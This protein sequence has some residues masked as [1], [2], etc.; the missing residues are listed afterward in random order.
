MSDHL[1]DDELS[2]GDFVLA[3]G[4]LGAL[5]VIETVA[6]LLPEVLGNEDSAIDESLGRPARYRQYTRP[7][8]F[9]GWEVPGVLRSGDH[10]AV[11]AWRHLQ[12]L[13]RTATRRPDLLDQLRR[14]GRLSDDDVR[15]LA[16]YGYDV[17]SGTEPV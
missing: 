4:E 3:G 11:A 1:V 15:S 6:R 5:V 8:E 13:L 16:A 14:E 9:R 10:A 17:P 7:A 2:V 12:S